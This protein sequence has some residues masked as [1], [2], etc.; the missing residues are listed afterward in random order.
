MDVSGYGETIRAY[1]V[2]ILAYLIEIFSQY[3]PDESLNEVGENVLES[4]LDE[5]SD[6]LQK[7]VD[8]LFKRMA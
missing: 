6:E 4:Y 5:A 3:W 1:K 7:V 8:R 2:G